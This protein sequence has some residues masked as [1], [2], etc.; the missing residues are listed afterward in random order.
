MIH[1]PDQGCP[2]APDA[3]VAT[4]SVRRVGDQVVLDAQRCEDDDRRPV[5]SSVM[6]AREALILA[7]DILRAV[8]GL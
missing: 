4:W 6:S 2:A 5:S 7:S 3:C 8:S 1:R